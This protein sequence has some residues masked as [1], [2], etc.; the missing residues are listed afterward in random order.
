MSNESQGKKS[1]KLKDTDKRINKKRR[2]IILSSIAMFGIIMIFV[3]IG[4]I[5][6]KAKIF[7]EMD[8]NIIVENS[9]NKKVEQEVEYTEVDGIT[10]VLLVG[11][12]SRD[13]EDTPKSDTVIIATLDNNVKKIKLTSLYRDT[14]VYIPGYGENK[15]N[16]AFELGG[17]SLL[18]K[19]ISNTYDIS[20]DKYVMIDFVGFEKIIDLLGGIVI[21]VQ[22]YQLEELN[23]YIGESTGGNDCPVYKSG[24]Q[25]L[26]GK[27]TLS[28]ARIRKGVG[29]DFERVERQREVLINVAEILKEIKPTKYLTI[30]TTM[31]DYIKTNID[32]LEALNLAY[33]IYK[34]PELNIEQLSIPMQELCI[35]EEIEGLGSVLRMDKY[36]NARILNQ[37]IFDDINP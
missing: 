18:S 31:L 15:L 8:N 10:N 33:T 23:K 34:F 7:M 32:P 25:V 37:F 5:Y 29:D 13:E 28:Y 14:L 30:M 24:L 9:Y 36:K 35:D 22:D 16:A 20:I 19:T 21:D 17:V 12:D 6:V 2:K 1:K 26:N 11:A 3:S 27:Q 4:Y